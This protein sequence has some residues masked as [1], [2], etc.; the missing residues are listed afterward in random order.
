MAEQP[1]KI[2]GLQQAIRALQRY[3]A[4]AEELKDS[5]QRVGQRAVRQAKANAP[6]R[7]GRLQASIRQSRAKASVTIR[8]G[9]N[10]ALRYATFNEFGTSKMRGT[11][12]VTRAVQANQ[13]YAVSQI[14]QELQ[15]LAAKHDLKH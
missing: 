10:G 4:E 9:N 8:S 6:Y 15:R 12:Y 1:V 5:M 14:E 7:S 13:G 11:K 2:E 3:G